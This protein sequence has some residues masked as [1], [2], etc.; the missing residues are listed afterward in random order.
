[1]ADPIKN[2]GYNVTTDRFYTSVELADTLYTDFKLTLVGTLK[3]NRKHI[4]A[5]LKSTN[6]R[7]LYS[8]KFAFTDPATKKP[9]V[10]L[11]S[12][13]TKEKPKKNLLMLS[14]QHRDA[15]VQVDGKKKSDINLYYNATKGGVDSIDQMARVYSVK[16]GTRRWPLSMFYSL[17][18]IVAIN[19]YALFKLNMP[20]WNQN[21]SNARKLYLQE[22]GLQL[23]KPYVEERS[24][25]L[26]GLQRPIVSAI[27][28][29]TG[30]TQAAKKMKRAEEPVRKARCY[31]CMKEGS[32]QR[33]R[34]N[35]TKTKVTCVNCGRHL[36]KK[37]SVSKV[38]CVPGQCE[39]EYDLSD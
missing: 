34:E 16:R 38:V 4:P 27:Q 7:E 6:G 26:R 35:I 31:V 25:D 39:T 8:T 13:I 24:K 30:K 22:L 17:I 5:E 19:S 33:E 11:V 10:T 21:K 28:Q 23:V 3:S 20:T 2:T 36:C 37:H 15:A 18:D 1:M 32:T 29:I 9:P 14:T 12:Y